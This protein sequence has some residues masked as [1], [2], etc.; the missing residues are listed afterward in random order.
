MDRI[1]LENVSSSD[2]DLSC[3]IWR[4]GILL[5]QLSKLIGA[6]IQGKRYAAYIYDY[7]SA[8]KNNNSSYFETILLCADKQIC[9]DSSLSVYS[10]ALYTT[11]IIFGI[12]ST[13][14]YDSAGV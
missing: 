1:G 12:T 4:H 13:N 9:T 11:I 5:R 8:L 10:I 6:R 14:S 3:R 7:S 2:L